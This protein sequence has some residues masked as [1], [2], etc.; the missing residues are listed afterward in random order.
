MND[1]TA[2]SLIAVYAVIWLA[3]AYGY[4]ANIVKIVGSIN[5]PITTMLI[6]RG[7]GVIAAPLGV[8]LGFF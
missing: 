5:E 3:V 7:I 1:K 2:W 6:F 4:I 8:V